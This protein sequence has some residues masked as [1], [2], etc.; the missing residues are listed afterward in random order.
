MSKKNRLNNEFRKAYNYY[1]NKGNELPFEIIKI[2]ALNEMSIQWLEIHY[3]IE[4]FDKCR[5][6]LLKR[7]REIEKA[8]IEDFKKDKANENETFKKVKEESKK[9][10]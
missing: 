1:S 6:Q 8:I 3:A 9:E 5:K 7:K 2:S 10:I 4:M